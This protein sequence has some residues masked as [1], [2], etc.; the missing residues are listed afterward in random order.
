MPIKLIVSLL[1]SIRKIFALRCALIFWIYTVR[2][3][4]EFLSLFR[5]S[6]ADWRLN[7]SSAFLLDYTLHSFYYFCMTAYKTEEIIILCI[8]KISGKVTLCC[9]T[10]ADRDAVWAAAMGVE[11]TFVLGIQSSTSSHRYG[12]IGSK[13]ADIRDT[14]L[15]C[16]IHIKDWALKART[17]IRKLMKL[18]LPSTFVKEP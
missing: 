11:A 10:D 8:L 12:I 2:I 3:C 17:D 15:I 13:T 6:Y 9:S 5:R 1:S 4:G 18:V 16:F 14:K 7:M